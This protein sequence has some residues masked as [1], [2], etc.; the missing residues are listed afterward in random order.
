MPDEEWWHSGPLTEDGGM[1]IE[2]G[3]VVSVRDASNNRLVRRAVSGVE[4]GSSFP[5]VWACREDE[6]ISA[7]VEGREPDAVPW[8]ADDVEEAEVVSA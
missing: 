4:P 6:W 1:A 2:R 5:V 7:G 8:P 3:T